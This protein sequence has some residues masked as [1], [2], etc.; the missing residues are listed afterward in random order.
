MPRSLEQGNKIKGRLF[1]FC[2]FVFA[3][4]VFFTTTVVVSQPCQGNFFRQDRYVWDKTS[5]SCIR[6]WKGDRL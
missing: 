1:F 4:F 5:N 3:I 6:L 2:I